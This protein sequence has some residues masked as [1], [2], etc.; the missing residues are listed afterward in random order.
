MPH[1][2]PGDRSVLIVDDDAFNRHGIAFYLGNLGY[3]LAEAGDEASALAEAE[4]CRP[5]AAVVD[6]VIPPTR[7]GQALL[8]QSIGLRLVGKLKQFDPAM[9]IV[10][11]SAHE[12][13]GGEVWDLIRDGNRGIAYLLKGARPEQLLQALHDTAAG[14]VVLD[15]IPPAGRPRLAEEIRDRL[16]PEERP[17]ADMAVALLPDLSDREREV[18]LRLANSQNTAGIAAALS[19]SVRTVENHITHVYDKLGLSAADTRAPTLRK[20]ALL[21]KAWMIYELSDDRTGI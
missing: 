7:D 18:A 3:R 10:I 11:F 20:S 4:R 19:I 8:S 17:W 12:D 5:W 15:G 1:Q 16:S 6:I 2:H 9:G 21:A 13:R 14:R